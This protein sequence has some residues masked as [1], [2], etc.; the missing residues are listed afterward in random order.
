MKK[1]FFFAVILYFFASANTAFA[2]PALPGSNAGPEPKE[3][4]HFIPDIDNMMKL[5][6]SLR[7]RAIGTSGTKKVAFILINFNNADSST[8][9]SPILSADDIR[10]IHTTALAFK[11]YFLEVS[12]STLT[13]DVTYVCSTGT[14]SVLSGSEVPFRLSKDMEDYGASI[15]S[16]GSFVQASLAAAN[17][18]AGISV[19]KG[20]PYDA[21]VIVHAGYGEESTAKTGD[22][23][24]V[25]TSGFSSTNG[26]TEGVV[27]AAREAN[28]NSVL[29]LFCHEFGHQLGLPDLY[30]SDTRAYVVGKWCL[31]DAG[32]WNGSGAHPA[33]LSAWCKQYLG[34]TTATTETAS[35]KKTITINNAE[36]NSTGSLYKFAVPNSTTEYFLVEYRR[37]IKSDV[38]LPGQ[39]ILIWHIDDSIGTVSKN[40]I[41][42]GYIARVKL[43]E[44]DNDDT[45]S[46]AADA[47]RNAGDVFKTPLSDSNSG[48]A[49]GILLGLFS[50]TGN[51]SMTFS[52]YTY[53]KGA[54]LETKKTFGYP[55]P[56]RA[57]TPVKIRT[58]FSTPVELCNIKIYN[59][60]GE[61]VK[62][63]D[64]SN[65]NISARASKD[66]EWA[67]EYTWDLTNNSNTAVCP[68]VY[69]Y[70][71]EASETEDS[72]KS[73]K[74][75]KVSIIR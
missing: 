8:S 54:A 48:T 20:S 21:V 72:T 38:S 11:E 22:L 61:L 41:N 3:D 16:S 52:T 30:N 14:A 9:G 58:V 53:L 34:W 42:N 50:G 56:S 62:S 7:A 75:G 64:L 67:Y 6:P 59:V 63:E 2:V 29:G 31:M 68:G 25:F 36:E 33:Q 26:F 70:V 1:I 46:E 23:W 60:A 37:W 45:I 17:S 44:A 12:G 55:S 39:G 13:I 18:V 71:I 57:G 43:V 51:S 5:A 66:Y 40:D 27:V 73:I 4:V 24:S 19:V 35:V 65:N 49:T 10:N 47:F 15:N 32:T 69:V 74:V 28:D